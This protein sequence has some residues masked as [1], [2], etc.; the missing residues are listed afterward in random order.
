MTPRRQM[1]VVASITGMLICVATELV[2]VQLWGS[3][4]LW[5]GIAVGWAL[6]LLAGLWIGFHG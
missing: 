6:A 4:G 3:A 5:A 2:A 1:Y